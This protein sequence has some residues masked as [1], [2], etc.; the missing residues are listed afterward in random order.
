MCNAIR[1]LDHEILMLTAREDTKWRQR[2]K[3]AWYQMG[4]KNTQYFQACASQRKQNNKISAILDSP[5][6]LVSM[7]G[8]IVDVFLSYFKTLL[9]SSTPSR[10]AIDQCLSKVAHRGTPEMNKIL[11]NEY[12][13]EEVKNALYQMAPLKSPRPDGFSASFSQTYWHISREEV[14][15][16]ILYFP[17]AV[18]FDDHINYTYIFLIPKTLIPLNLVIFALLV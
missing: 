3:Q 14:L 12:T 9:C 17:N 11:L 6:N 5:G 13:P 18:V 7:P 4:D 1:Q 16:T 15:S 10:R 8:M 2:A